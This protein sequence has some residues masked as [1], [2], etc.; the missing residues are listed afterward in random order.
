[1]SRICDCDRPNVATDADGI[2]YC[3]DCSHRLNPASSPKLD[4]LAELVAGNLAERLA[5]QVA[6][7]SAEA[8]IPVATA[9][10]HLACKPQRIYDLVSRQQQS[11]IPVKREGGRLLFRRSELDEWLVSKN[12][13]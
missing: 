12:A 1:M 11:G 10:Q 5:A 6:D 4:E 3:F 13:A 7:S 8:W 9:A 2:R